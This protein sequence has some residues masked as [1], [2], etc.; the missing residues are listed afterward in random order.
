MDAG[1]LQLLY[2]LSQNQQLSIPIYQR[3]YSWSEKECSQ[4]LEDILRVGESDEQ[5]HFIGSIVYMNQKGHIASPINSLMII[6]GQQRAT[7]ITLLIS[8]IVE[9]LFKNP[10][11]NVMSPENFISYYLL[12]D[13]EKGETR[14]KL[15]LT[16]DDKRTLIK[17]IDYLETSDEIPFD[18]NDSIRIKENF[19]FFK[20][21]INTD[22]I[23]ILF[24]GLNKLLIIFVALEHNIDNPQLIFESL[25]STGLELSQVDL[26]RNYILMGLVPEEQEKLYNDFWHE[27]ETLFEKNE[28]NFDKFI[29]DYLTVKT[30]K[31]PVFRNIYSDFKKYSAQID[32]KEL[33]KDIH[34]YAFYFNSIAFGA[35]ENP[36]LKESL[37]S[38]NSL[39]YDVTDPFMLHLY[40]DYK[41]NK[42]STDDFCEI[43]KYTESYLL[44]RL[45]CS[46]PTPSLNKTFAGMY[47]QIDNTSHLSSYKA[48]LRSKE[49]YQRMPSNREFV[50]NFRQRDIYNLRSKNRDYIFDKFENWGSKEKTNIQNYTIEHI[51]P[52]NPNLSQDWKLELGEQ[53]ADIQKTYLHTIGNLTLTGYNSELSDRSFNEKRDMAGGFKDSAIRLNIYLQDLNNWNENEIKLR[54]NRF[55]EKAKTIWPYP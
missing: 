21:K 51:M 46:I 11:D 34:K 36:K 35:E 3:K 42:L 9:F 50:A 8:A 44:R 48:I 47:V 41:E 2:F 39:G 19:E 32:V 38:L 14:Y 37:D 5:N 20:K 26:I 40:R 24:N 54:T 53:W 15:I 13:R 18:S 23:E 33:V 25:N 49:N 10:N 4:L 43:I 12:N 22:N 30:D 55:V 27:I 6:D 1:K 45:I 29:R 28:G 16:Q 7:T 52:Q 31:V 17:I